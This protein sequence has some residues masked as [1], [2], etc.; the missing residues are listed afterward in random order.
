MVGLALVALVVAL[1]G[2][3]GRGPTPGAS[4]GG[5]ESLPPGI[6]TSSP[7]PIGSSVVRP[8]T[9]APGPGASGEPGPIPA[10]GHVFLL[11]MENK[12]YDQ[13]IGSS[14]AP[15]LN[16][17]ANRY[18]LATADT[19]VSHPSQPNYLALWSGSTQGVTDDGVH[20]ITA[21]TLADQVEASGR[22]WHVAAEN[23]PLGCYRG[24]TAFGGEDGSGSYARKHEPAI[25]FTSVSSDSTR[26]GQIT[27]FRHFDPTEGNL[28][29]IVPNLCDDTHDCPIGTGDAF[30]RRFLPTI[31]DS[32]A[33]ADGVLFIT[34]DEGSGSA[35][36]GGRVP[37]VVVSP[38]SLWVGTSD[39]PHD[40]YSILRT[41]ETAW[42]LPCLANACGANDLRELFR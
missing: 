17:L 7:R 39:T 41:I 11:V 12:R 29:L 23:V 30:L 26:C 22:T 14:A 32:P 19:A 8:P 2:G 28:W 38:R 35:G 40:H 24:A 16:D 6:S 31:L 21:P 27:D 34:W 13:V 9:S 10:F 5:A 1:V 15:Y 18:A 3:A 33:F 20:D 42:G 25:S 37:L 4:S 36:G